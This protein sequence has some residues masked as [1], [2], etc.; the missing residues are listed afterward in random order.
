MSIKKFFKKLDLNIDKNLPDGN[1]DFIDMFSG[2]DSFTDGY[3]GVVLLQ[4]SD[5]GYIYV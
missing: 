2:L 3:G 1:V 4:I 5:E